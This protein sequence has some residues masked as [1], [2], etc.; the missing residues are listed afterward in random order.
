MVPAS[1]DLL[2]WNTAVT[3]TKGWVAEALL[4]LAAASKL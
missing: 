2:F 3:P 4:P 1:M